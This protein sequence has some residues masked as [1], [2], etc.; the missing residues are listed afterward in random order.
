MRDRETRR[1]DQRSANTLVWFGKLQEKREADE[2]MRENIKYC[3]ASVLQQE[4]ELALYN[5]YE[6]VLGSLAYAE[7]CCKRVDNVTF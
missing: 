6:S 2:R 7:E 1:Q 4:S 3:H 5:A